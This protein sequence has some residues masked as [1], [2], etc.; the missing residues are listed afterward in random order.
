MSFEVKLAGSLASSIWT[1]VSFNVTC[2]SWVI[3]ILILTDT[4]I[5][6]KVWGSFLQN[7]KSKEGKEK[8]TLAAREVHNVTIRT[9]KSL[10][11]FTYFTFYNQ[12]IIYEKAS[13]ITKYFLYFIMRVQDW[14]CLVYINIPVASYNLWK[15][16]NSPASID[17]LYIC[18][19]C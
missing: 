18:Y 8:K 6:Y 7:F 5:R 16:I 4:V 11:F 19:N 17:Y 9:G 13:C 14:I 10:L 15:C 2:K 12:I 1:S 3:N